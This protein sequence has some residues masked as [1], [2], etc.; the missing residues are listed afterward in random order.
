MYIVAIAWLYVVLMMSLTEQSWI[1]GIGTFVFYGVAPL[2]LFL[3][4]VGTPARRRRRK[5]QEAAQDQRTP[6]P[7]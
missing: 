4:I 1:A 6:P 2:S 5:A 7:H 3:W